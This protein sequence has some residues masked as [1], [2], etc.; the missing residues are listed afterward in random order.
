[1]NPILIF[2]GALFC[3]LGFYMVYDYVRFNKVAIKARGTVLRY[4]EYMSKDKN[5]RKRKMYR[6]HFQYNAGGHVY[7]V[8]SSTSFPAKVIPE[9]TQTEVLYEKGNEQNARLAKG[10]NYVLGVVFILLGL[11]AIYFG[12]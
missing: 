11:P 6:P 8:K 12:V 4:D 7:E 5:G 1:M 10:N 2:A 9:G 3:G